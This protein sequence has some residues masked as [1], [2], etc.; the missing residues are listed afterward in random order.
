MEHEMTLFEAPS[1][2]I[3]NRQKGSK[4]I[5]L[6]TVHNPISNDVGFNILEKESICYI[7]HKW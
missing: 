5:P 6:T 7:R 3:R 4:N 2:S 1:N